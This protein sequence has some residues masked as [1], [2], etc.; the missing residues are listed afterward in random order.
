MNVLTNFRSKS[1]LKITKLV[2]NEGRVLESDEDICNQFAS[3]FVVKSAESDVSDCLAELE[4]YEMITTTTP[5]TDQDSD[6][7][8]NSTP[9]ADRDITETE[10]LEAISYVKKSKHTNTNVPMFIYKRFCNALVVPLRILLMNIFITGVVPDN[11]KLGYVTPLYK[12]KGRYTQSSSYRAIFSFPFIVRIY[13][14]ILFR[15]LLGYVSEFFDKNQHGF[16]HARS[17]ETAISVFTQDIYDGLDKT[18]GKAVA[19][20]IDFSKAFDSVSHVL[21]IRKLIKNFGRKIPKILIELIINYFS[22][23]KFRITNGKYESAEYYIRAGVPPG[24]I[25]GALCYTIFVNDIGSAIALKYLLYADDLVIYTMCDTFIDGS[26]QLTEALIKLNVWCVENGLKINIDKTKC[27]RFYKANDHRARKS[28]CGVVKLNDSPVEWVEQF[29]Y[30]GVVLDSTLT[31][32]QHQKRVEQKM[33]NAL[34]RLYS[35]RRLLTPKVMKIFISAYV[36]SIVDYVITIWAVRQNDL[37]TIQNKINR[38]VVAFYHPNSSK[39]RRQNIRHNNVNVCVLL[40]KID[41]L[42]VSERRNLALIKCIKKWKKLDI[43]EGF[44]VNNP[45]R[46]TYK[47]PR[48]SKELYK[49]SIKWSASSTWNHYYNQIKNQLSDDTSH[50]ELLELFKVAI[51]KERKNIYLY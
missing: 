34:A 37:T 36:V 45:D 27:M 17:C 23:R 7:S 12:G 35:I 44:F 5:S 29:T 20:F 42:T 43:F 40:N 47:L 14:R 8:I 28:E 50:S 24:S 16:R 21:L 38:F 41:L 22:N 3:E 18:S 9:Y 51:L 32:K 2:S 1:N 10:I 31:F 6:N 49:Q 46:G 48:H 19:V 39:K 33:N 26:K 11:F 13:E 25:L 15:R 30:L 4:D